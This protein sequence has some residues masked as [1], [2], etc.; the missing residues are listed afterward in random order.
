MMPKRK[1]PRV[2]LSEDP[3]MDRLVEI[4]KRTRPD[5][6]DAFRDMLE[7][8]IATENDQGADDDTD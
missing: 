6:Q 8:E 1:K 5:R 3:R 4:L 7:T 2:P